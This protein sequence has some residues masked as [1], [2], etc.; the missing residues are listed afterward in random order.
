MKVTDWQIVILLDALEVQQE[1]GCCIGLALMTLA[2]RG[3]TG[4]DTQLF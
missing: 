1:L 4:R 2:K 3:C